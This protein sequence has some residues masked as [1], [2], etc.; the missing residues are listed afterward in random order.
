[1]R[2]DVGAL[3]AAKRRQSEIAALC[4]FNGQGRGRRHSKENF[5]AAGGRLLHHFV[6]G[7]GTHKKRAVEFFRTRSAAKKLIERH[8][9]ADIFASERDR[10]VVSQPDSRVRAARE[11]SELF[12]LSDT[13]QT[14]AVVL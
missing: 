9:P 7:A 11:T 4:H 8:M 12:G 14:R 2:V 6:G 5:H 10:A 3:V 13:G 1:M